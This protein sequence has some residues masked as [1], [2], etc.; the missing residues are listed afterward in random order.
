[1]DNFATLLR[2]N[3]TRLQELILNRFQVYLNSDN[4]INN[5]S[6]SLEDNTNISFKIKFVNPNPSCL[7]REPD[8]DIPESKND[9]VSL[10][11]LTAYEGVVTN[12]EELGNKLKPLG[13]KLAIL[14]EPT[15]RG[16]DESGK[17]IIITSVVGKSIVKL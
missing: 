6:G 1:M 7:V 14:C 3:S 17:D 16:K 4:N 5:N 15:Y 10:L 13:Y 12:F 9:T 2:K 11:H 8:G